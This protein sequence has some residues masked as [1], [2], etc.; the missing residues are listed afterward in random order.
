[1]ASGPAAWFRRARILEA[2]GETAAARAEAERAR[3]L[4]AERADQPSRTRA[5]EA[6]L[7]EHPPA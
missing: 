6:W 2:A 3:A 7:A 1:M 5:V 4:Y